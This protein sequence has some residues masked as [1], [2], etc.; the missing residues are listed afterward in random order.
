LYC[1][2]V[3]R[4]VASHFALMSRSCFSK[5]SAKLDPGRVLCNSLK[6][7]TKAWINSGHC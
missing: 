1:C 7:F 4:T 3:A 2:R 6:F 5:S